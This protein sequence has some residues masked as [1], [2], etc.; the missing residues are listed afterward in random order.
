MISLSSVQF[1]LGLSFFVVVIPFRDNLAVK[2]LALWPK[3]HDCL[4]CLRLTTF[5]VQ[6][7]TFQT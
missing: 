6:C 4:H 2:C 1:F 7:H 3:I 5:I